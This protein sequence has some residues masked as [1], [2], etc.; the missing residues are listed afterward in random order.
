MMNWINNKK[1]IVIGILLGAIAGL[2]YWKTV[3]CSSGT[4]LITSKWH[5][6]T[7]YGGI[8][9]GLFFSLFKKQKNEPGSK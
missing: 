8:M 1:L 2:V 7:A 3:G 4:C 6:S 9:G 5:N